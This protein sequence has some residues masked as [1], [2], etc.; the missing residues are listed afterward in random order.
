[1]SKAG[2]S[3]STKFSPGLQ[4]ESLQLHV[5]GFVKFMKIPG[6]KYYFV[7]TGTQSGYRLKFRDCPSHSGT[8]GNYVKSHNVVCVHCV[9][10]HIHIKF[11]VTINRTPMYMCICSMY[12]CG[13]LRLK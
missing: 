9:C 12:C 8:L 5:Q 13:M 7:S 4:M 3:I 6:H 1:M 2:S 11:L 10:I